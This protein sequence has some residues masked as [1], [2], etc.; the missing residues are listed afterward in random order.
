[1]TT[2]WRPLNAVRVK[3]KTNYLK[4]LYGSCHSVQTIQPDKRQDPD[5]NQAG[6]F[7]TNEK[8][9]KSKLDDI[10]HFCFRQHRLLWADEC[11]I[12][13]RDGIRQIRTYSCQLFQRIAFHRHPALHLGIQGSEPSDLIFHIMPQES[14]STSIRQW[15][16][17]DGI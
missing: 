16:V 4:C 13:L 6:K 7:K 12:S 3:N 10:C 14:S 8:K 9:R 11:N 1:M 5:T 2:L 17:S 15:P